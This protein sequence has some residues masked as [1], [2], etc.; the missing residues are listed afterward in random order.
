M[1]FL[2]DVAGENYLTRFGKTWR[3]FERA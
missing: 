3:H 2:T 1:Y